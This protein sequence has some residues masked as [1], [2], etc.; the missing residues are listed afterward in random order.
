MVRQ[1]ARADIQQPGGITRRNWTQGNIFRRQYKIKK[2]NTH[3]GAL[4]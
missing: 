3:R 1:S 4:A 2:V